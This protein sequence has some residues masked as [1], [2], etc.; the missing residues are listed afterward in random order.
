MSWACEDIIEWK[1]NEMVC[2]KAAKVLSVSRR[3]A[4]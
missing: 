3:T 2:I 4:N 1:Q